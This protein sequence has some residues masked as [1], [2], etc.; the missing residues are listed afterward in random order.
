MQKQSLVLILI[1]VIALNTSGAASIVDDF[2][3]TQIDTNLW[4]V[5]TP[6]GVLLFPNRVGEGF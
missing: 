3:G 2:N 6:F 1:A 5:A 4:R